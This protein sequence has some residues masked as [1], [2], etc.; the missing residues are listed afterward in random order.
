L[1]TKRLVVELAEQFER[2]RGADRER[3]QADQEQCQ[4]VGADHAGAA[5]PQRGPFHIGPQSCAGGREAVREALTGEHAGQPLTA[6]AERAGAAG[7]ALYIDAPRDRAVEAAT[8]RFVDKTRTGA[9]P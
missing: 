2:R 4:R 6:A 5:E 7:R 1:K 9:A 8:E 3:R